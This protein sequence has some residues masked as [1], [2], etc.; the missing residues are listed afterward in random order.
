MTVSSACSLW[1]R[2]CYRLWIGDLW[3]SQGP[4]IHTESRDNP[5]WAINHCAVRSIHAIGNRLYNRSDL[6]QSI[7][8]S[9]TTSKA[10]EE[11]AIDGHRT[12]V[13]RSQGRAHPYLVSSG[14]SKSERVSTSAIRVVI[15]HEHGKLGSY[16]VQSIDI[17]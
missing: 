13:R 6:S 17:P 10:E 16:S 7:V 3:T 12:V 15:L 11:A 4:H 5:P 1:Y 2:Q 14:A 9:T 8:P